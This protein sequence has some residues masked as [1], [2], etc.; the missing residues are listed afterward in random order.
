M[1]QDEFD[2][3]FLYLKENKYVDG[4]NDSEKRIL[5][6]KA[7]N[8]LLGSHD[9]LYYTKDSR[10]KQVVTK[11]RLKS[12]LRL[13]H[14]DCGSHLGR[15]KTYHKVKERYFWNTIT[16]DVGDYLKCCEECQRNNKKTKT[17]VSEMTPV[18]VP[19]R[20]WEKIGIDLIGPFLNSKK[21]T[22]ISQ[23]LSGG[24][25]NNLMKKIE[26]RPSRFFRYVLTCVDYTSKWPE[27]FPIYSKSTAEVGS[28]LYSTIC[29]FGVMR[30]IVS[31]QGGEFNSKLITYICDTLKIK[32]ITTSPYHPQANGMVEKFNQTLK[33]MINKTI[34]DNSQDWDQHIE[35]CLFNYRT[36]Y[37]HSTK[38]TPFYVMYLRQA[39]LPNETLDNYVENVGDEAVENSA[40][41]IISNLEVVRQEVGEKLKQNVDKAQKRQKEAYDRRHNVD[42]KSYEIGQY[43]LLK[44]F[45]RKAG[46]ATIEQRKYI[47][48]YKII[49][50]KGK[51]NFV[52][53]N[54]EQSK[55]VGPH[56]QKNF[57]LWISNPESENNDNT[58]D[59]EQDNQT[60]DD[61]TGN[62]TEQ[63]EEDVDC[64]DA[65]GEDKDDSVFLT[66]N[67]FMEENDET[68]DDNAVASNFN[69]SQSSI[70]SESE[71][72][73]Q[74]ERKSR[75][76]RKR[77][78]RDSSIYEYR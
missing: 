64:E 71:A 78:R 5:R 31:D 12:V 56:N 9:N 67:K 8:F 1:E 47:G 54:N 28:K 38:F 27:A 42:T 10:K 39:V 40:E 16:K 76:E 15:D 70:N 52:L 60:G 46:M 43:V 49:Q 73:R 23:W 75:K 48:P 22:I 68:T 66:Q 4:K 55:T 45:R 59:D 61:Q 24:V 37:H 7:K 18:P 35:K 17:S 3:I 11:E 69:L 20:V 36:S 57:K 26:H 19:E 13:C 72:E 77:K 30:E 74:V 50:Y 32:H 21:K 63:D 14:V 53:W 58:G 62:S 65:G 2:D 33:G 29:R 41:N 25:P 51:G 44:N 6:R 34:L